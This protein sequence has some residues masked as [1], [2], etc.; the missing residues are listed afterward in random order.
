MNKKFGFELEAKRVDDFTGSN[1]AKLINGLSE[2][3][4]SGSANITHEQIES[5][6][7]SMEWA[8]SQLQETVI[9]LPEGLNLLVSEYLRMK[10]AGISISM[11]IFSKNRK[12]EEISEQ[13][14]Q[15]WMSPESVTALKTGKNDRLNL[16]QKIHDQLKTNVFNTRQQI[17]FAPVFLEQVVMLL[18]KLYQQNQTLAALSTI[19]ATDKESIER[20]LD[21]LSRLTAVMIKY[22]EAMITANARLV[23]HVVRHIKA[24]NMSFADLLQEGNIG[25]IKAVDRYDYK[26]S[27]RF[28]TY[29]VYWIRQSISRAKVRNEKIVRM[30][31]NLAG[32]V[33]LVFEAKN[34]LDQEGEQQPD[35][36]TI[37]EKA[38]LPVSE[39]ENILRYYRRTISMTQDSAQQDDSPNYA[40][41]LE[42]DTF[43]QPFDELANDALKDKLYQAVAT[44][45]EREAE[46]LCKRFGLYNEVEMTLQDIAIHLSL[47]RER[48]RQIQMNGLKKLKQKFGAE[49]IDFMSPELSY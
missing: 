28:S 24:E 20:K 26:L 35:Y 36:Q 30:P 48:V 10:S 15:Q 23:T 7:Q 33:N 29:A 14:E 39:V 12:L 34:K 11:M 25:L 31:F 38:G 3:V 41:M 46:V 5:Y 37:A 32:K 49:L 44:L 43:A 17:H 21:N 42:Q 27:V 40:D 4:I 47:T 13:A 8:R 22:R 16:K 19:A 6:C 9:K 18:K 2:P 45:P 1:D